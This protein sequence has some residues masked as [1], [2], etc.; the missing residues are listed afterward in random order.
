MGV[1]D[2][3]CLAIGKCTLAFAE[4][5]AWV[6]SFAWALIGPDQHVGQIVTSEMSFSRKIDLL[7]SLFKHRC[8]NMASR[9]ELRV[10]LARLSELEQERNRVQH[11]LWIRQS[12]DP[13]LATRLKIT[14]RRKHGLAHAK[15]EITSEPLDRLSNELQVAVSDFAGFMTTFLSAK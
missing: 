15:E 14:A 9:E 10:L 13:A 3:H 1:S 6:S 4:L 8:S 12:Q 7:S 11:S 5:D 2:E